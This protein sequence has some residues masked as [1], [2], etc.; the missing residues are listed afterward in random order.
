MFICGACCLCV[1]VVVFS[2]FTW[3]VVVMKLMLSITANTPTR[4]VTC[5]AR[6][7]PVMQ[8]GW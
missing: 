6:T 8:D 1:V 3:L 5:L 7:H 2:F 4:P